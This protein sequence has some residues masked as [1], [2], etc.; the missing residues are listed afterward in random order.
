MIKLNVSKNLKHQILVWRT[1]HNLVKSRFIVSLY[2][3]TF[4]TPK[5]LQCR[6]FSFYLKNSFAII[7][8]S[9]GNM[10]LQLKVLHPN[11]DPWKFGGNK[12]CGNVD[13]FFI[14]YVNSHDHMSEERVK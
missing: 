5:V 6:N 2:P 3:A 4:G 12:F 13:T 14:C 11:L 10:N 1:E 8:Q 7:H 9:G